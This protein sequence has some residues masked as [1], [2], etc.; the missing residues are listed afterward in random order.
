[1]D[2][3]LLIALLITLLVVFLI[4]R[5]AIVIPQQTVYVIERVGKF[6]R[7]LGAGW[8]ILLP[9]IEEIK[10]KHS[11]KETVIDTPVQTCI[12]KDNVQVEVDAI[13]YFKII[14]PERASYGVEDYK[15]SLEQLAITTLRSQ[16]GRITLEEAL[17]HR[18]NMSSRVIEFLDGASEAWG[19]KVL[20]FEIQD[21]KPPA[22]ISSAMEK[23]LKA[24]REKRASVLLSEGKRDSEF[25]LAEADKVHIIRTSEAKRIAEINNAEAQALAIRSLAEATA[26]G[27]ERVAEAINKPGGY[28]ASQLK[29]ASQYIEALGNIAKESNTLVLPANLSDVGSMMA[30]AQGILGPTVTT[31]VNTVKTQVLGSNNVE[32]SSLNKKVTDES[33]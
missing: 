30:L 12:T 31:G 5:T 26:Q 29:L 10:Y 3:S 11:L 16:I 1:M 21:I 28:E 27:I 14:N 8:H 32:N 22:D 33:K 9:F 24:E 2:I 15:F 18:S 13:L 17:E 25:N 23:Q 4:A 7:T 20:R 19:I 6:S